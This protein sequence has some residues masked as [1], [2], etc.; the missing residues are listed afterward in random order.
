MCSL[1]FIKIKQSYS[2]SLGSPRTASLEQ[3]LENDLK[4]EPV[5]TGYVPFS[6]LVR[7]HTLLAV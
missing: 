7:N 6:V 4:R 5:P 3:D 2:V 1:A